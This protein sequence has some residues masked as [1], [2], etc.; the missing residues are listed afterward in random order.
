[1]PPPR[2]AWTLPPSN[3][4]PPRPWHPFAHCGLDSIDGRWRSVGRSS[5]VRF[6]SVTSS[7]M[8]KWVRRVRPPFR[9]DHHPN[10]YLQPPHHQRQRQRQRQQP[11]VGDPGG[12][13]LD[14]PTDIP[15]LIRSG[16]LSTSSGPPIDKPGP[17]A[18]RAIVLGCARDMLSPSSRAVEKSSIARS[19]MMHSRHAEPPSPR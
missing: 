13:P 6:V 8:P 14:G 10:D 3:P 16:L 17:P 2:M 1:M 11:G 18:H 5:R 9:Y 4:T 15:G 7:C 12:A 19:T